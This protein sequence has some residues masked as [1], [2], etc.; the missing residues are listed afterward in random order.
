MSK[1]TFDAR[2]SLG[3]LIQIVMIVVAL[4]IGWGRFE[5][6]IASNASA[7]QRLTE[8]AQQMDSEVRSLRVNV[9]RQDERLT[10]IYTLLN[11]IDARLERIEQ[12]DR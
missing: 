4:S 12:K 8:S 1:P 6:G 2:I 5:A 7:V 11:R 9:T 3:N 10:G